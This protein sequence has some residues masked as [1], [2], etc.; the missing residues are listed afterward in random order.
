MCVESAGGELLGLSKWK[1]VMQRY[2]G[3]SK[4]SFSCV[5]LTL[6]SPGQQTHRT[7]SFNAIYAF[8]EQG[9]I[10]AAWLPNNPPD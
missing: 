2:A 3:A 8:L 1:D 7:R 5:D 9:N 4:R 10:H 6:P